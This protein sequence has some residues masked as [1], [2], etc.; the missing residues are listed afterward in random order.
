MQHV[1]LISSLQGATLGPFDLRSSIDDKTMIFET[2]L[3]GSLMTVKLLIPAPKQLI[4][5]TPSLASHD[6][7]RPWYD[8]SSSELKF[9]FQPHATLAGN[10]ANKNNVQPHLRSSSPDFVLSLPLT[11]CRT[12]IFPFQ[13]C[14]YTA[15][16]DGYE[17][18]LITLEC[19][20]IL[21]CCIYCYGTEIWIRTPWAEVRHASRSKISRGILPGLQKEESRKTTPAEKVGADDMNQHSHVMAAETGTT[22]PSRKGFSPRLCKAPFCLWMLAIAPALA[23]LFGH[24]KKTGAALLGGAMDPTDRTELK[25][26]ADICGVGV[27]VGLYLPIGLI[28]YTISLG[29]I[30]REEGGAKELGGAQLLSNV[31][32]IVIHCFC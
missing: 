28:F 21:G 29:A 31:N 26:D 13:K 11:F 15:M 8:R 3:Y 14:F 1:C 17:I 2:L 22:V 30:W 5:Y 18:T 10:V 19:L 25:F 23:E 12:Q 32:I 6:W 20:F 4:C 24:P 7:M 27:R 16:L 9:S